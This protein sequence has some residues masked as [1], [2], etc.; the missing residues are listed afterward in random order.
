MPPAFASWKRMDAAP[1]PK[2]FHDGP[3]VGSFIAALLVQRL[4]DCALPAVLATSLPVANSATARRCVSV[5]TAPC[6]C[7][8]PLVSEVITASA[9]NSRSCERVGAFSFGLPGG[10]ALAAWHSAHC[11]V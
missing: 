6:C 10:A 1:L 7:I 5:S 2:P 4:D 8:L 11:V 3:A 9:L